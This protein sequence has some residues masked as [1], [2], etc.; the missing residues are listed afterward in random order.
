MPAHPWARPPSR[1]AGGFVEVLSGGSGAPSIRWIMPPR[2]PARLRDRTAAAD[3]ASTP[4]GSTSLT[5]AWRATYSTGCWPRAWP[6]ASRLRPAGD[7]AGTGALSVER[8]RGE[9]A[10]PP[11][12]YT[13]CSTYPSARS[14]NDHQ[15]RSQPVTVL[16]VAGSSHG[17]SAGTTGHQDDPCSSVSES[18]REVRQ[19]RREAGTVRDPCDG[20]QRQHH[21][22]GG[23]H[24]AGI[25]AVAPSACWRTAFRLSGETNYHR[26]VAIDPLSCLPRHLRTFDS[27]GQSM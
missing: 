16:Q 15:V 8:G 4:R 12:W 9:A 24:A 7:E 19:L 27:G 2:S 5:T 22:S 17:Q 6:A 26:A 10:S 13:P 25:R 1:S 14:S 11:R 3:G 18:R 23:V 21:Q 20:Q